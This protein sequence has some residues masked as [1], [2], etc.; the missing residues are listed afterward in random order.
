MRRMFSF[1]FSP[2]RVLYEWELTKPPMKPKKT[3]RMIMTVA[4]AP[5]LLGDRN[6]S[7]ANTNIS[8]NLRRGSDLWLLRP[9]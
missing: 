1:Q 8:S 7:N 3:Y 4:N 6:P 5:R 2:P 9:P